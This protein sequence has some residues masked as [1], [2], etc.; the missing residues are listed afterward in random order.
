MQHTPP[1]SWPRWAMPDWLVIC[2]IPDNADGIFWIKLELLSML[3]FAQCFRF[4]FR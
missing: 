4:T 2:A 1:R 3:A